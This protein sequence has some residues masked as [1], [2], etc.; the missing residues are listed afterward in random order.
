LGYSDEETRKLTGAEL[1]F[2][3]ALKKQKE[4]EW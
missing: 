1:Y 3:K 2:D 4:E